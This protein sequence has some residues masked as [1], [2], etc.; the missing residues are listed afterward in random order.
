[1]LMFQEMKE[2]DALTIALQTV[3]ENSKGA[4]KLKVVE[5]ANGKTPETVLAP[6][7]T[8]VVES[9]PLTTVS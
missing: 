2:I 1:M 4:R 8:S 6:K 9:E 5:I 3:L 7:I